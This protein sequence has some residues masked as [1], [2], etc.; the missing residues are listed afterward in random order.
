MEPMSNFKYDI[1]EMEFSEFG[2]KKLSVF[3]VFCVLFHDNIIYKNGEEFYKY[4]KVELFKDVN[5]SAT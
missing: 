5:Y 1:M 3:D 2:G 4:L